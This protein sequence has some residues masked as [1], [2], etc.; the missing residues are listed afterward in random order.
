MATE[1]IPSDEGLL[2]VIRDPDR[3]AWFVDRD[4]MRRVRDDPGFWHVS[5]M[6]LR[7]E[8]IPD[9]FVGFYRGAAWY[10]PRL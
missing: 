2:R 10:L 8:D 7:G 4:E 3:R 6:P 1:K 5:N 9:G